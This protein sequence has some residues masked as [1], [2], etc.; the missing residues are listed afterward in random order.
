[1]ATTTSSAEYDEYQK[2]VI[3]HFETFRLSGW[4]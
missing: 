3:R 2:G 4:I 1:M